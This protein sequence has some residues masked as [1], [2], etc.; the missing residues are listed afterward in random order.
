MA[1]AVLIFSTGF[2]IN[3]FFKLASSST[4]EKNLEKVAVLKSPKFKIF[5]SEIPFQ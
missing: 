4:T 3:H 1:I 5:K 2:E